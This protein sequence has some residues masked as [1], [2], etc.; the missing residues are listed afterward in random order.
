MFRCGLATSLFVILLHS[1]GASPAHRVDKAGSCS[2]AGVSDD[3]KMALQA[4]GYRLTGDAGPICEVWL[5]KVL[6]LR[7]GSTKGET[8]ALTPGE[9]IGVISY[10][11]NAADYKGQGIKPGVYTMRYQTMP[12]D[13]NHMG[14]S[15]TQE[16][17]LLVP[18]ESDKD[19][20]V[21]IE[22]EQLLGLS[23]KAAKTPH[24]APL[25]LTAPA[26]AADGTFV[27]AGDGH[28]ALQLK[29]KGQAAGGV[30]MDFQ[31]ALVLIGK[32]EG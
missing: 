5:R 8:S 28:W 32:G 14:V 4:E 22:Y 17:V 12:A 23:R 30:E 3:V 27:D 26:S 9:F 7:A 20:N 16:Y 24:P 11:S 1:A 19:P 10:T 29:T 31:L 21:P 6:A 25:Y 15:P 2:A 13:G 18:A